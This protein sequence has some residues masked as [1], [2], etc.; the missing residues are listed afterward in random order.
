MTVLIKTKELKEVLAALFKG[1]VTTKFPVKPHHPPAGF[2]GKPQFDEA[3][4]VGCGSCA[5]VCPSSAIQVTDPKPGAS[6]RKR[7]LTRKIGLRYDVCNFCGLCQSRCITGEGIRL[8]DQ[9]DLALLDKTLAVEAVERELVACELC[10]GILT[11]RDH[12]L[13]IS[14]RLGALAYANPT[15]TRIAQNPFSP[16]ASPSRNEKPRREDGM[17]VLCPV[18]RRRVRLADRWGQVPAGP[19]RGRAASP[20][21]ITGHHEKTRT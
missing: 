18:C 12:L 10:G 15:L 4:C 9:F 19:D 14:S 7:G 13:W 8:T 21:I 11:T 5:K 17:R 16:I 6:G 3:G 1:P 2:R 20:P